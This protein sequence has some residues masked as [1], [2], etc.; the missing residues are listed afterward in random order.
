MTD[1]QVTG[2]HATEQRDYGLRAL[3]IKAPRGDPPAS[4]EEDTADYIG[5]VI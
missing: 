5:P 1:N 3:K 2:H 4:A